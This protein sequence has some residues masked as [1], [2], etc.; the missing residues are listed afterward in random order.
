MT[1]KR[2]SE[3]SDE[4]IRELAA[5]R[6]VLGLDSRPLSISRERYDLM[7]HLRD[8][9][10]ALGRAEQALDLIGPADLG[11]HA[12]LDDLVVGIRTSAYLVGQRTGTN[13][14]E[15]AAQ[16]NGWQRDAESRAAMPETYPGGIGDPANIGDREAGA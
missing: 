11:R 14:R 13:E 6:P 7:T 3:M 12:A 10:E 5:A 8:A 1:D 4:E 2:V 15:L 16:S 9:R